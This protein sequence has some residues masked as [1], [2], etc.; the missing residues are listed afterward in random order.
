M[1]PDEESYKNIYKKRVALFSLV[2]SVALV[3]VKILIA[4]LSNS[5]GVFSEAINNGL[6]L[7]AVLITFLAVRIATRPADS[8]HT[9][10]HENTRIFPLF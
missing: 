10:G 1:N 3:L 2:V 8:N 7:V 5:M 9:Y 6:D 4:V